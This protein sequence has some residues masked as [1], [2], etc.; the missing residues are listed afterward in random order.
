MTLKFKLTAAVPIPVSADH[1][2]KCRRLSASRSRG[3]LAEDR[4]WTTI[5][6]R[7]VPRVTRQE[8]K[9]C[10]FYHRYLYTPAPTECAQ[11]A[12]T[13][14]CRSTVTSI[15]RT[16]SDYRSLPLPLRLSAAP[17]SFGR[18]YLNADHAAISAIRVRGSRP[19][20]FAKKRPIFSARFSRRM[21]T[22]ESE[23]QL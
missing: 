14:F 21:I 6:D 11:V 20:R 1:W 15:A 2:L 16:S 9:G 18:L 5:A 19:K 4:E 13:V 23:R 22:R 12:C 3:R 7:S 10:L 17:I 8:A